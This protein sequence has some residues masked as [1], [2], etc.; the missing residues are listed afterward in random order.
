MV[1]SVAILRFHDAMMAAGN[2]ISEWSS[3]DALDQ[4]PARGAVKYTLLLHAHKQQFDSTGLVTVSSVGEEAC[5]LSVFPLLG[6][7]LSGERISPFFSVQ[8][9]RLSQNPLT[10]SGNGVAPHY[11]L[12]AHLGKITSLNGS[13]V[14]NQVF[15]M[16]N[17]CLF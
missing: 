13:Q 16:L 9:V 14:S 12:I 10:D 8:E 17:L 6:F 5:C 15:C 7:L 2:K 4:F 3:V 1:V 11:M